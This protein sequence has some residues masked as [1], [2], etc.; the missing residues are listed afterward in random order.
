MGGRRKG[1]SDRETRNKRERKSG[2][3]ERRVSQRGCSTVDGGT[4]V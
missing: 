2:R 3:K 1:E 4:E